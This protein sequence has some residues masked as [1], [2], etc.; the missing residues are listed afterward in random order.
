MS[1]QSDGKETRVG[2]YLV[3]DVLGSGPHGTV[4]AVLHEEKHQR[5]TLKRLHEPAKGGKPGQTFNR[6]AKVLVAL[7]HPMI[8]DVGHIVMHGKHVAIIGDIVEG[9]PLSE[10]L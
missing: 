7:T 9:R 2:P 1:T 5:L 10:V 3:Q 4:Y 6:I 8:A